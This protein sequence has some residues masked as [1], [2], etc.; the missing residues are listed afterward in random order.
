MRGPEIR[1][2]EVCRRGV[3][4]S[5]GA[6]GGAVKRSLASLFLLPVATFTAA[7]LLAACQTTPVVPK[8]AE[9]V[10]FADYQR[11]T[12]DYMRQ[13]RSFQTTDHEAE[14]RW[15]GPGEWRP[16][17]L[18]PDGKPTK[19]VL[20]VHG[21]GDSPWSFHD[22]AERLSADGFLV[23]T[24][25]LQG[26]GTRP[27]DMLQADVDQWRKL[28]YEQAETLMR[29]VAG[30]VYLGGFSTGA[31]LVLE[32]AYQR[33]EFAGLL[34]FSPGFRTSIPLGWIAP[35]AAKVMDWPVKPGTLVAPQ[36]AVRYMA[37][38]TN[39]FAFSPVDR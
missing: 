5:S 24:V 6:A 13:R 26:H 9:T 11:S 23:R 17:N 31:N 39:G 18:R 32:V 21:L 27:E 4:S 12:L 34:L 8:T 25:L 3:L 37:M 16:A 2:D 33:P 29:D 28:V 10:S 19:G 7:W 30:P 38:P 15:N 36:N 35:M 14:L 20:L 22:V 1:A